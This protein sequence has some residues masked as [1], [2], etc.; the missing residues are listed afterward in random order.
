MFFKNRGFTLVELAMTISILLIIT[1]LLIP[2]TSRFLLNNKINIAKSQM[3]ALRSALRAYYT[4]VNDWPAPPVPPGPG[5]HSGLGVTTNDN[6]EWQTRLV[7]GGGAVPST[8]HGPY[9]LAIPNDPWGHRYT[10][11]NYS[12]APGSYSAI[13]CQGPHGSPDGTA[14]HYYTSI[15]PFDAATKTNY[16][17]DRNGFSIVPG[18]GADDFNIILWMEE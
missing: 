12:L 10:Y 4:D 1:V 6:G 11:E 3:M 14:H 18:P 9:A 16:R 5:N 13:V 17:P 15:N 7:A 2:R 8:W